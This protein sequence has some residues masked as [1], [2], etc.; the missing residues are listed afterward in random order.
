MDEHFTDEQIK[1]A[2]IQAEA[3]INFEEITTSLV[4]QKEE[5][6]KRKELKN[7]RYRRSI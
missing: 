6:V 2:L 7:E 5:K 1:E 3:N 4:L